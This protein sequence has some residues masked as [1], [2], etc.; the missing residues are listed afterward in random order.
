M[1]L[2][3][4]RFTLWLIALCA[5]LSCT[6]PTL[7][8]SDFL[9]N[10]KA[11]LAYRDDF[12]LSFFTEKTDSVL[13]HSDNTSLQLITYLCGNVN[14][15]IFGQY[16]AEIYAQPLLSATAYQ[17]IGSTLDS[18]ILQLRYDTF[19]TYG[20]TNE[21]V[22]IEVFQM[23]ENPSFETEFYSNQRF[24]SDMDLLGSLTF[25]PKPK[26][27]VTVDSV[28]FAPHLRIPIDRI[29]VRDI[30]LQDSSVFARQDSF[31]NYFNGLHIRMSSGENT[32]LGFDLLNSL[33]RLVFYYH[34][35]AQQGLNFPYIFTSA[36]IKTLYLEHDYTGSVVESALTS[37][38]E[39]DHFYVQGMSGVTT[40]M[41]I[42]GLE[43]LGNVA[44]NQAEIEMY[45]TFPDGDMG[46][47]Y[48]PIPYMVIQEPTDSSLV[49]IF[50]VNIALNRASGNHTGTTFAI[51]FG[52]HLGEP[53]PGPPV[54]FKYTMLVT[55][56]VQDIFTG[57]KE[58]VLYFN[59][60]D[61]GG[62][63]QRAVLFGPNH[64]VYA[65]KLKVFYTQLP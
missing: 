44:I 41:E 51:L 6:K 19:G 35:D 18:V 5:V 56:Q 48:P 26:D 4:P 58:N 30:L 50:D 14:D 25:V 39:L 3:Y 8:G 33:S 12:D 57:T 49:N 32:M 2:V 60:F 23:R 10:E 64:P 54:V 63:P 11:D 21:P 45:A 31:L 55:N 16:S 7:I 61:K 28:K 36:S 42:N 53:D 47:L 1:H 40:R 62:L 22:T 9:E 37:D 15:P 20:V 29:K 17:L 65:P 34:T 43:T 13:V 46:N 38:P 27:S 59:P 52:G 24:M